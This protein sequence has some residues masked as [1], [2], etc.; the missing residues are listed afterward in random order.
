VSYRL[1]IQ[2]SNPG[3]TPVTSTIYAGT[4]FEVLDAFSRTQ[5]LAPIRNTTITV[6]PGQTQIIEVD[7]WCINH[8][9]AAPAKRQR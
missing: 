5:S 7:S 9:F 1:K 8:H 4:V 3:A 2:V 6:P